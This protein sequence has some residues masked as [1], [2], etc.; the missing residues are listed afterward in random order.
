M[1]VGAQYRRIVGRMLVGLAENMG[2]LMRIARMSR[3]HG[4]AP[5]QRGLDVGVE[6]AVAVGAP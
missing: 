3:V 2:A 5:Q 1:R 4:V 6:R